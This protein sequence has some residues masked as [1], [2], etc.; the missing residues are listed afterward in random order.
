MR[1]K[2]PQQQLKPRNQWLY[3]IVVKFV[4]ILSFAA[5]RSLNPQGQVKRTI[6]T[7]HRRQLIK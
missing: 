3:I 2:K 6:C 5:C 7:K 4:H 1:G